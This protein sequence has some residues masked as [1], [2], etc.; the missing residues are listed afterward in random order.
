MNRELPLIITSILA[1]AAITFWINFAPSLLFVSQEAQLRMIELYVQV[2]GV[3]LGF[4]GV[5]ITMRTRGISLFWRSAAVWIFLICMVI[6]LVCFAFVAGIPGEDIMFE[7]NFGI[8]LASFAFLLCVSS[9]A[10]A[11]VRVLGLSTDQN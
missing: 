1:G 7:R 9:F 5:I 3:L 11:L 6:E 8:S 10:I 2:I 4:Y